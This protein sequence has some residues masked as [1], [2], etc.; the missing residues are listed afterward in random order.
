MLPQHAFFPFYWLEAS[1]FLRGRW[2]ASAARRLEHT[3][4]LHLWKA[5][6]WAVGTDAGTGRVL[7]PEHAPAT[8]RPSSDKVLARTLTRSPLTLTLVSGACCRPNTL[9]RGARARS[10][11]VC[12]AIW[13][14]RTPGDAFSPFHPASRL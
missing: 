2:G 14:A 11:R 12:M 13:P 4:V 1:T 10:G 8:A 9:R 6:A 7:P 3:Y 5:G